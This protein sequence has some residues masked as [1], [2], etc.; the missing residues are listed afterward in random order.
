MKKYTVENSSL[1]SLFFATIVIPLVAVH[2][3]LPGW[4]S[5]IREVRWETGLL[6]FVFGFCWGLGCITYAYGFNL[7]GMALAASLL[8]GVSVAVG[9]GVP[10]VRDWDRLPAD[11]KTVT[12]L[13]IAMLLAGTALGGRAGIL[14]E[15][16]LATEQTTKPTTSRLPGPQWA[17]CS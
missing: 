17:D 6:V 2:F 16:E 3:I 1:L 8:K 7:L 5:V 10:L 4:T 11:A 13:G 12:I 9:A 14:R 15:R